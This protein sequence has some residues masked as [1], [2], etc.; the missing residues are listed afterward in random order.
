LGESYRA[1][2]RRKL[3]GDRRFK[4]AGRVKI[5]LVC[6]ER[7][8]YAKGSST[9]TEIAVLDRQLLAAHSTMAGG[10]SVE[11]KFDFVLPTHLPSSFEAKSNQI[12]W[13]IAIEQN[14][15]GLAE[16]VTSN[17]VVQVNR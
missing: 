6:V 7:A 11:V 2:F 15:P 1:T 3:R 10:S 12:R 8:S 5:E 17:F 13:A 16:G 9:E 14:F 4:Q